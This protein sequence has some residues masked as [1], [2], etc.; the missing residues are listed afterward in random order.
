VCQTL[1]NSER[2]I[3]QRIEQYGVTLERLATQSITTAVETLERSL[4]KARLSSPAETEILEARLEELRRAP[5]FAKPRPHPAVATVRE[6]V[7]ARWQQGDREGARLVA[8]GLSQLD[9]FELQLHAAAQALANDPALLLWR[10]A[11]QALGAWSQ[12]NAIGWPG[13]PIAL[14]KL[15]RLES[16]LPHAVR[17]RL[18]RLG[19]TRAPAERTSLARGALALIEGEYR[20]RVQA[21]LRVLRRALVPDPQRSPPPRIDMLAHR[22]LGHAAQWRR[23]FPP[24]PSV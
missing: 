13:L 14:D 20:H 17:A 22:R 16:D 24:E 19:S 5:V 21:K 11:R 7:A 6:A 2:E 1:L 3:W 15:L 8:D 10:D 9:R 18:M 12:T 23:L 4:R